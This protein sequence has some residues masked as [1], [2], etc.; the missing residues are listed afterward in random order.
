MA[1]RPFSLFPGPDTENESRILG[2][3]KK[4]FQRRLCSAMEAK[5]STQGESTNCRQGLIEEFGLYLF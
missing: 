4:G 5:V 1:A 3:T 2:K